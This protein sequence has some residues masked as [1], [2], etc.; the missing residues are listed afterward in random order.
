LGV[1]QDSHSLDNTRNASGW[2]STARDA[3]ALLACVVSRGPEINTRGDD[4]T[5]RWTVRLAAGLVAATAV[6]TGCSEKQPANETLPTQTAA[7][8]TPELPPL[9]PEDM[10]M[11]DEARTQD[12]AGAE[13][14]V[15]YYIELINRTSTVMDA[16]PLR[17]FS[18]G[19]RDCDR[20]ASSTEEAAAAGNDYEG[21]D[22][23]IIDVGPPVMTDNVASL[24]IVV[25]QARFV[26][27]DASGAPTHGGSEAYSNITGGVGLTWD[28]S[29]K[30]WLMTDMTF[31]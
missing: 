14:F 26:V 28:S 27:L 12:A 1:L 9:G 19:C 11:P 5:R 22:M 7:E 21:G 15:R 3:P 6:L 23:T 20:I 16:Q 10:P 4:V 25:D 24:P 2:L 13:A 8:T 30:T 31:G 18:A 29:L 17:Q